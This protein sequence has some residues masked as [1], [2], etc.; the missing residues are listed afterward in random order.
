MSTSRPFAYNT[1]STIA[2]TIQVGSLAVGTPISGFTGMEWWNGADEELGFIIAQSISAD[3]QP[4]PISGVTASVGFDRTNGFDE[5]EF[6]SLANRISGQL[7]STAIEASTGLTT[8]GYWNSYNKIIIGGSATGIGSS[9]IYSYNGVDYS[10][11][12][13]GSSIITL[14]RSL[15]FDGTKYLAG[16]DGGSRMGYSYDGITWSATT[17]GSS[18]FTTRVI[19]IAWDGSTYVSVGQGTNAVA[20]S[21]DGLTWT[22]SSNGNTF[23]DASALPDVVYSNGDTFIVGGN[24]ITYEL[25]IS[26]DGINWTGITQSNL[27]RCIALTYNGSRWVAGGQGSNPLMYSDDGITWT[28]SSNT[29]TFVDS[30]VNSLVWDGIKFLTG[31]DFGIYYSYDAV[32]WYP[33]NYSGS[34]NVNSLNWNG[35][36]FIATTNPSP[37]VYYSTD[38]FNWTDATSADSLLSSCLTSTSLKLPNYYPPIN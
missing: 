30:T 4:T 13:N 34:I 25:I 26:N 2:G 32:I 14:V 15:M 24:G 7:F 21:N 35:N 5:I 23:F 33:T 36:L 1:G 31:G 11:S 17:N 28:G 8:L 37:N 3:T 29:N 10:A 19:D 20:Y 9:I 27:T 16:G 38:G 12:T 6:V 18:I 22:G